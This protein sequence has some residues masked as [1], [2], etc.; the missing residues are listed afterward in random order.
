MKSIG[1]VPEK[2]GHVRV[3]TVD[4]TKPRQQ[5]HQCDSNHTNTA[6]QLFNRQDAWT[7]SQ[8]NATII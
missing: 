4:G 3:G 2:I 7:E 5:G 6:D 8:N 1:V